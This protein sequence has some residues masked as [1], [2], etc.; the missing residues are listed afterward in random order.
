M[1]ALSRFDDIWRLAAGADGD[2]EVAGDSQRLHLAG[3]N[4][5]VSVVIAECGKCGGVGCKC[6]GREGA[7]WL[8]IT[9]N[10]LCGDVLR[11]S[12]AAPISAKENL[13]PRGQ[14]IANQLTGTLNIV[15]F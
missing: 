3:E 13:V 8:F 4:I 10:Q 1:G 2:Q 7:A 6:D 12:S 15:E 14:G 9:T 5:R 11:V